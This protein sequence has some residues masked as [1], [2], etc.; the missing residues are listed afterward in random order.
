VQDVDLSFDLP[1]EIRFMFAAINS[2]N[3]GNK[4]YKITG[5]SEITITITRVKHV[6]STGEQ[7]TIFMLRVLFWVVPRRVAFNIRRF[8]TLCPFHL[9][10]RVDIHSHMKME[11]KVLRNVGY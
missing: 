7:I 10:R 6:H 1:L 11:Q 9:H 3:H 5:A 4:T 2:L 8:G